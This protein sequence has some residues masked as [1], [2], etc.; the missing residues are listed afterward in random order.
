M[1]DKHIGMAWPEKTL[2]KASIRKS[3]IQL[4]K[5]NLPFK[6]FGFTEGFF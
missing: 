2:K 5:V 3:E 6:E 1:R 4:E